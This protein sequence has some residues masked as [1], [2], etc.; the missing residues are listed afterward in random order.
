MK[1]GPGGF[2]LP[3]PYLVYYLF[4]AY[5]LLTNYLVPAASATFWILFRT[6]FGP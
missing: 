1:Q 2:N 3:R 4:V 6:D 5:L